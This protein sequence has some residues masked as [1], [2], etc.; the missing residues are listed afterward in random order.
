MLSKR[1]GLPE[2]GTHVCAHTRTQYTFFKG[3]SIAY[4]LQYF[5]LSHPKLLIVQKIHLIVSFL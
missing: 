3:R 5:M 1:T 2:Q 4:F